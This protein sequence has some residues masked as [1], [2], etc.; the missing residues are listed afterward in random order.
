MFSKFLDFLY[1]QKCIFCGSLLNNYISINLGQNDTQNVEFTCKN[2]KLKLQY[3]KRDYEKYLVKNKYFDMLIYSFKY[4]GKI[5]EFLLDFKFK[6]KQFFS[7]FFSHYLANDIKKYLKETNTKIDYIIAVPISFR[8][9]LERGYNQSWIIADQISKNLNI[10][11]FKF[12]LIKIKHNKR[13]SE[14]EHKFRAK[15]ASNAYI[16]KR[17][18]QL[19]NKTILLIDDIYTTGA[20]VNECSKVLI[21]AGAKRIIVATCARAF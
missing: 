12:S 2:C 3:Y 8:R 1:P 9:Y 17:T 20:T 4:T 7:Y 18:N 16:V 6:D 10:C 5:R 15:N 14:L 11:C 13:Q 21:K 19:N